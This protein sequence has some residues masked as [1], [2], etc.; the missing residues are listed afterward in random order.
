V[1]WRALSKYLLSKLGT[2]CRGN[3]GV[4]QINKECITERFREALKSTM[5]HHFPSLLDTPQFPV[6]G[7]S[8]L[9]GT[10]LYVSLVA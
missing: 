5:P 9:P 3:A 4:Y 7:G 1:N 2:I 10:W 8:R 6:S